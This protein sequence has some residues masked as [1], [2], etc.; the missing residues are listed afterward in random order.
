MLAVGILRIGKPLWPMTRFKLGR[1]STRGV[2]GAAEVHAEH[3]W[4]PPSKARPQNAAI[5]SSNHMLAVSARRFLIASHMSAIWMV[6]FQLHKSMEPEC[7][8]SSSLESWEMGLNLRHLSPHT[9]KSALQL[10]LSTLSIQ[11]QP[12]QE[13]IQHLQASVDTTS[14]RF[15]CIKGLLAAS[16]K[17]NY[18]DSGNQFRLNL[19]F[20]S[21]SN[22]HQYGQIPLMK[23]TNF[24]V[25]GFNIV[26]DKKV[27][28][29]KFVYQ[30]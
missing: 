6:A 27:V 24:F 30:L 1:W 19:A 7:V 12:L 8:L 11:A 2:M 14:H 28:F 18:F 29:R 21:Y 22:S 10:Q 23:K 4:V 5:C 16:R 17:L 20:T 15:K 9:A 3:S 26:R 13:Q 25:R